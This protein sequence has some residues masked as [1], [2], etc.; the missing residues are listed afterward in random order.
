MTKQALR[1]NALLLIVAMIWGGGFVAGKMAL[2]AMTPFA[3][4][5]GVQVVLV[6]RFVDRDTDSIQMS[7]FQFLSA[8]AC[9]SPPS[10]STPSTR[11]KDHELI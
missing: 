5:F 11:G 3:V 9:A 6:A 4:L 8:G 2:T 7:F 10:C 1:A